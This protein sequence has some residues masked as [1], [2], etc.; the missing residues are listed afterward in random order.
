[1]K[2]I[3]VSKHNGVIDWKKVKADGVEGVIIRAGYG[4]ESSQKDPMFESNYKNA[5]A[6]GLHIGTYFYTYAKSA[7]EAAV[8]ASVFL[9]WIKGKTFD[10][11]VYFDIE[12]DSISHLSKKTLTEICLKWCGIVEKAGYYTGIYGNPYWFNNKL[13]LNALAG[14][15]KWLAHWTDKPAWGN[16]FGGMWQ[17]SSKGKVNGIIGNVDMNVCY[18]DYPAIIKRA[19]LNGYGNSSPKKFT[20]NAYISDIPQ[21]KADTIAKACAQMGMTTVIKEV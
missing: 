4:R 20:V 14:Y 21:S 6:Q 12:D 17:Y 18:R 3:D 13:D 10:L 16:E 8:E 19:G 9:E 2:V 15:D 7:A 11:P 5:K 1:M